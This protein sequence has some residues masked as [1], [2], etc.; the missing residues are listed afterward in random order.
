MSEFRVPM[1][2]ALAAFGVDATITRPVPDDTPIETSIVWLPPTMEEFPGGPDLQRRS[3]RRV[4]GIDRDAVPT[5]PKGTTIVAPERDGE[6]P[7]EWRVDGVELA[8]AD[9]IRAVVVPVG[10]C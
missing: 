2:S 10:D 4:A 5:V 8:D 6:D 7:Q 9:H 1:A 3:R